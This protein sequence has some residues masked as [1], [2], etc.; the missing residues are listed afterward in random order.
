MA[1]GRARSANGERNAMRHREHDPAHPPGHAM[2]AG[3]GWRRH[4]RGR[5]RDFNRCRLHLVRVKRTRPR[6]VPARS[7]P[8]RRTLALQAMRPLLPRRVLHGQRAGKC[9]HGQRQPQR[10]GMRI[11]RSGPPGRGMRWWW[12]VKPR[13]GGE[14]PATRGW[15]LRNTPLAPTARRK[16]PASK[17][18]MS[19]TEMRIRFSPRSNGTIHASRYREWLSGAGREHAASHHC[20]ILCGRSA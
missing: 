18:P 14:A 5:R 15:L 4:G 20:T 6:L 8:L 12:H 2:R 13:R 10:E 17:P 9:E 7:G 11:H 19:R 1:S 3:L 16:M